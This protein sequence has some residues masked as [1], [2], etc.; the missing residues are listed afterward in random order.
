MLMSCNEQHKGKDIC[1]NRQNFK[2]Y[3]RF[4]SSFSAF[5][6]PVYSVFTRLFVVLPHNLLELCRV[7][8]A[9]YQ[10]FMALTKQNNE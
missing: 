1:S 6:N 7:A 5:V 3:K 9:H 8:T 2:V 4:S 10:A